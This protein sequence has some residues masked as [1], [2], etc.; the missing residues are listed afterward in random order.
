MVVN[1]KYNNDL[2]I[3]MGKKVLVTGHT[4]FM[5][6][7]LTSWLMMLGAQVCGYSLDPQ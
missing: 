7:W 4:G 2:S 1:V 5:G 3:Y 6:S